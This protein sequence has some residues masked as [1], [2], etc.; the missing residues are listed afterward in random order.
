M[1]AIAAIGGS[2]PLQAEEFARRAYNYA[3]NPAPPT[4]SRETLDQCESVAKTPPL[5]GGF[6]DV[7]WHKLRDAEVHAWAKAGWVVD[8]QRRRAQPVGRLVRPRAKRRPRP[9]RHPAG[10]APSSRGPLRTRRRLP[11][12][13]AG[14]DAPLWHY[15]RGGRALFPRHQLPRPRPSHPRRSRRGIR[16]ATAS[17]P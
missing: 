7:P 6:N 13:G 3:L 9:P 17:G 11:T 8:S 5:L 10:P 1:D 16:S 15:L 4:R 14:D 12:R 2:R